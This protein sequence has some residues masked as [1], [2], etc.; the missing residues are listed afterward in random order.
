MPLTVSLV[1]A[2]GGLALGYLVY[3][4][5]LKEGQVDPVRKLLGPVWMLWHHKYY[6][7]EI[8]QDSILAFVPAFSK[9][10]ALVD[11]KWVIDPIVNAVGRL[12]VALSTCV[13]RV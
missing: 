3:G 11:N 9:F 12:G 6:I 2:L 4:K 1:V 13:G 8:Y 7:D 5:G 10:L